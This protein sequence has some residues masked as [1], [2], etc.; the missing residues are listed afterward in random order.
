MVNITDM[1]N[2]TSA[3]N[4]KW[5]LVNWG[6]NHHCTFSHI[7][8]KVSDHNC[9]H[10]KWSQRSYAVSPNMGTGQHGWGSAP[11][12]AGITCPTIADCVTFFLWKYHVS[13]ACITRNHT[14]FLYTGASL[15]SV[16]YYFMLPCLQNLPFVV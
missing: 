12:V 10:R 13:V 9:N 1:K 4:W 5:M 16:H 15:M 7:Y 3:S 11:Q 14:T 6:F 2:N 8:F